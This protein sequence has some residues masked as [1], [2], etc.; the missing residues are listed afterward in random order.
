[1]QN[2]GAFPPLLCVC[3]LAIPTRCVVSSPLVLFAQSLLRAGFLL[4]VVQDGVPTAV[5]LEGIQ[6][7]IFNL[8][9]GGLSVVFEV[10]ERDVASS[11]RTSQWL[12]RFLVRLEVAPPHYGLEVQA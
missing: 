11:G 10:Q 2:S 12:V 1:M 7:A 4:R 9:D 3:S 8:A 5:I 6:S